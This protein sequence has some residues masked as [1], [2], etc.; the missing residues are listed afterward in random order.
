MLRR[1]QSLVRAV[2]TPAVHRAPSRAFNAT[3]VLNSG[4][5]VVHKDTDY[6]NAD[7]PWDFTPESYQKIE[8]VLK[9]FPSNYK[10]SGVI[11]LL[12][13]AQEQ[14]DNW[15]PL[16][17]MNKIAEVLDMPPI[18]VYE[19]ASFYTMFNR[20]PVGKF[21][22]QLCG[23]TPCM[24][25]GSEAIKKVIEDF[26]GIKEGETS[27]D[28]L[29][30]L[31]EVECLGACVNAPMIQVNNKEFYEFLTP[32]N[33]LAIMEDWKAGR[34]P[35]PFNQNHVK[36]CEGPQGKTTLLEPLPSTPPC[37]DLDALKAEIEQAKADSDRAEAAEKKK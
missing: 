37:R 4:G 25:T 22:I 7:L 23:T 17:A 8:V 12:Y 30:T 33:M 21:H 18:R 29:F 31:T 20:T 15:L 35:K 10:Q 5:L 13:I 19:V 11:P 6:N 24:V 2:R 34:T 1:V 32:E 9:K 3:R 36:T 26:A 28:G 27:K 14:G 16:S